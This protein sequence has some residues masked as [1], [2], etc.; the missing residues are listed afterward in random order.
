MSSLTWAEISSISATGKS[1]EC[2]SI[3]D[4]K[5]LTKPSGVN[6]I[7][8]H[9]RGAGRMVFCTSKTVMS[10]RKFTGDGITWLPCISG[11]EYIKPA[12]DEQYP[13]LFDND[14]ISNAKTVSINTA[15]FIGTPGY[16]PETADSSQ[17]FYPPS[18]T[19]VGAASSL[20]HGLV[21]N[22]PQFAYFTG[23]SAR[24]S[25]GNSW[26]TRSSAFVDT[27]GQ[28][29]P[30]RNLIV[31]ANGGRMDTFDTNDSGYIYFPLC[32]EV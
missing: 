6:A 19:E 30:R 8:V 15:C 3:G 31:V 28:Q 10:V 22:T 24:A 7:F 13:T 12:V 4:T 26:G 25:I 9:N 27:Y 2:F 1:D 5:S 14:V 32:F 21:E 18:A 23:A 29:A 20:T 11:D 17:K 16:E